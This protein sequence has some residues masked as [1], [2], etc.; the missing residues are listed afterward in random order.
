[1]RIE[2]NSDAI[3]PFPTGT[4]WVTQILPVGSE[5]AI[6]V[7]HDPYTSNIQTIKLWD[8]TMVNVAPQQGFVADGANVTV[9][10][11]LQ[12][13]GFVVDDTGSDVFPFSVLPGLPTFI[14]DWSNS[15]SVTLNPTQSDQLANTDART[16]VVLGDT[17]PTITD[18]TGAHSFT[19][20]ELFTGKALDQITLT[21]VTAGPSAGPVTSVVGF[22][23]FGVIVR[24]DSLPPN[25][26]PLAP[27][28]GWYPFDLAVLRV[29]RGT[30]IEERFGIHTVSFLHTFHNL[31]GGVVLNETLL[32]GNPPAM[33]IEVEFA[34]GVTGQVYLM[35]FP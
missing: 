20:A 2:V 27:D 31:Y 16:S 18:A 21:E 30:D 32:F 24:I 6:L 14:R 8:P 22:W 12:S 9:A 1:M 29:F 5:N 4:E 3:G 10:V 23:L 25:A 7:Q 28:E 15:R 35:R 33:S 17:A 11:T 26:V 13:P 34:L 19:L